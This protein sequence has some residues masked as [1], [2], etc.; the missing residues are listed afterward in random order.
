MR[1]W[2]GES[3]TEKEAK[4][5]LSDDTNLMHIAAIVTLSAF[6]AVL[7]W[8]IY[9]LV[10]LEGATTFGIIMILPA[11]LG[12]ILLS[13]FLGRTVMSAIM[14]AGDIEDC[15]YVDLLTA[16]TDADAL[17]EEDKY[18]IWNMYESGAD[19]EYMSAEWERLGV[20]GRRSLKRQVSA[21]GSAFAQ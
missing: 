6:I 3:V 7:G 10:G 8:F 5:V 20:S 4:I 21:L 13:A 17:D 1:P 12:I 9:E 19:G 16:G 2:E 15:D 18:G 11:V 14:F